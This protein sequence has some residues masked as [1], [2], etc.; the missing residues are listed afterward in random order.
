MRI[1]ALDPLDNKI[2][3]GS[4]EISDEKIYD[5]YAIFNS[6][7]DNNPISDAFRIELQKIKPLIQNDILVDNWINALQKITTKGECAH[8]MCFTLEDYLVEWRI[9]DFIDKWFIILKIEY[10]TQKEENSSKEEIKKEEN[11]SK[12]EIKKEENSSK[13][14]IQKEENSSKEEIQKEE[15]I[16][17]T[18]DYPNANLNY[19]NLIAGSAALKY[20]D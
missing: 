2:E 6:A 11:S 1:I 15:E 3:F 5:M 9:A 7:L 14:E 8:S 18:V 13:E 16:T 17:V 4:F 10:P 12:E 19:F 20:S